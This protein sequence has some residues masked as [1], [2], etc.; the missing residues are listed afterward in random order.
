MYLHVPTVLS[1]SE[2][3][4]RASIDV[5]EINLGNSIHRDDAMLY[6]EGRARAH[7]DHLD[8]EAELNKN[9]KDKLSAPGNTNYAPKNSS[10]KTSDV[11]PSSS[12]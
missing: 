10:Q 11:S 1:P 6:Y 8:R 7:T 3:R 2:R 12:R 4:R 5:A 9:V